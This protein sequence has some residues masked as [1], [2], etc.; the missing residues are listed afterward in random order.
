MGIQLLNIMQLFNS[1]ENFLIFLIKNTL[2]RK[3]FRNC[4][5]H[6]KHFFKILIFFL[7]YIQQPPEIIR[8][9]L[10]NKFLPCGNPSADIYSLGMILYQIL[11]K[12]EPFYERNQTY[13]SKKLIFIQNSI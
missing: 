6:V 1:V 4:K 13:A 10:T 7:E 12:L 3:R 8:E 2:N 5:R 11:F 9:Y